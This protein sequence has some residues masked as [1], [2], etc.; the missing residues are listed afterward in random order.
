MPPLHFKTTRGRYP[1]MPMPDTPKDLSPLSLDQIMKLIG[2]QKK[3]PVHLWDPPLTQHSE[4]RILR[5]GRWLH[6]GAEI[7]REAMV[8]TFAS[9]LRREA[10]D[11]FVLVTPVE[12]QT[13]I[14]E[15]APFVAVEVKA[16]GTGEQQALAFR[17]NTGALVIAGPDHPL[18]TAGTMDAPAHY[19]M[20]RDGLEARLS[21]PVYYALADLALDTDADTPGLW[22]KGQFFPFIPVA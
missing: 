15:D 10:D 1:C 13:I 22:S 16:E 6:Q 7:K 17:L 11:S 20:V 3:P 4:M 2:E 21:R 5:D 9:I 18:R 19:L 12:K 14:V 8:R